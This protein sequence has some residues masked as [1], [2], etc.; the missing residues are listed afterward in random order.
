MQSVYCYV[1]PFLRTARNPAYKKYTDCRE[2]QSPTWQ[3]TDRY[4]IILAFANRVTI[5]ETG[6]VDPLKD[7]PG[8]YPVSRPIR[9][10]YD[11]SQ[12]TTRLTVEFRS[13]FLQEMSHLQE[14]AKY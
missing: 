5:S 10:I 9:G 11:V 8:F 1:L 6:L 13:L 14:K 4:V 3:E 2:G 7:C 12:E